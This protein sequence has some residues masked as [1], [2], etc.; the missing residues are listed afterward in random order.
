MNSSSE[1]RSG[2]SV[3]RG[4][5]AQQASAARF[6]V[7]LR[8]GVPVDSA[9]VARVKE[10][11]R[12]AGYAEG[13]AQGQREA[14]VAAQAVLDRAAAA[15]Q[16]LQAQR[17]AA[18]R[19]AIGAVT[20]AAQRLEQRQAAATTDVTELIAGYAVEIAEAILGRELADPATRGADALRRVMVDAPVTGVVTV[21]LHPDDHRQ[22]A[23]DGDELTYEG[24]TVVLR[25]DATLRPGDAVAQVGAM[26]I[27]G[28]V[29]A[30]V[31]R[32]REIL[33]R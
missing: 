4:A 1:F 9:A 21:A 27:D 33:D 10:E 14:E 19:Q 3:L 12:T 20:A 2:E 30:A 23:L 32:V 6:G 25:A 7:D 13:W 22:L 31:H 16:R 26:T 24:R 5:S 11:A 17:E 18:L 8:K 29:A 28:T 15:E